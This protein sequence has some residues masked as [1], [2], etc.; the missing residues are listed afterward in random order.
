MGGLALFYAVVRA[1]IH[2]YGRV[3]LLEGGWYGTITELK[4][5]VGDLCT[6]DEI[7]LVRQYSWQGKPVK[8]KPDVKT[9]QY[10]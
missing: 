9:D 8:I 7:S 2:S 5:R 6:T 3:L 10:Y 1:K 4:S